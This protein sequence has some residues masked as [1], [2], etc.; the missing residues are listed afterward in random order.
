M[1]LDIMLLVIAVVL[2]LAAI[3]A[4]HRMVVGPTVLDRAVASDMLIVLVIAGMALYTAGSGTEYAVPPMLGLTAL[5]FVGT[6]VVARFVSRDRAVSGEAIHHGDPGS[7]GQ[8]AAG[9][10]EDPGS[11]DG[12]EQVAAAVRAPGAQQVDA[13]ERADVADQAD[14]ADPAHAP[15]PAGGAEQADRTEQAD[16]A[17]PAEAAGNAP[18]TDDSGER[19]RHG[20]GRGAGPRLPGP[21]SDAHEPDREES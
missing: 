4:V 5:A 14:A 3:P 12:A 7:R 21:A 16:R 18:F 17:E 9:P 11:G 15:E 1:S 10:A 2:G 19:L 13:A 20:T 6:L 8:V